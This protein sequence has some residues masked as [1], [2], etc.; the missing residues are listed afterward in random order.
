[1]GKR[2]VLQWLGL[3]LLCTGALMFG[4]DWFK[5]WASGIHLPTSVIVLLSVAALIVAIG[6]FKHKNPSFSVP[7]WLVKTIVYSILFG[8]FVAATYRGFFGAANQAITGVTHQFGSDAGLPRSIIDQRP[9]GAIGSS[10]D[11]QELPCSQR[12]I[13]GEWTYVDLKSANPQYILINRGV[14]MS[15]YIVR[16]CAEASDPQDLHQL[17]AWVGADRT[18]SNGNT[19]SPPGSTQR[20]WYMERQVQ[21]GFRQENFQ[22]TGYLHLARNGRLRGSV[23]V[24]VW[25]GN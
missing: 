20:F 14:I 4:I 24:Y 22:G 8:L 2:V 3:L 6:W 7:R 18:H 16:I 25:I 1:M 12:G 23:N 11:S 13:N 9:L 17:V 5:D 19:W 15:G 10:P 21:Y